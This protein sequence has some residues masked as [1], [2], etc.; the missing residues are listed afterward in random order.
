MLTF[1]LASGFYFYI[2]L[3]PPFSFS[4]WKTAFFGRSL[5]SNCLCKQSRTLEYTFSGVYWGQLSLSSNILVPLRKGY[6][7]IALTWLVL[8]GEISPIDELPGVYIKV[9]VSSYPEDICSFSSLHATHRCCYTYFLMGIFSN[10]GLE[11]T[12]AFSEY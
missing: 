2:L 4:N 10:D 8:K 1:L 3:T 9:I 11:T 7:I 5:F 12:Y 6:C